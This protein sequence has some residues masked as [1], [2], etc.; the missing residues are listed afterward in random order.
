MNRRIKALETLRRLEERE[1]TALSRDLTA[2]QG[3]QAQAQAQVDALQKRAQTEAL[4]TA[5]EALPYIGRFLANLRRE[6]ARQTQIARNLDSTIETL[7]QEVLHHFAAEKTF[8]H[9][10]QAQKTEILTN[11]TRSAEA[12]LED[13][14]TSRFGRE[15][16]GR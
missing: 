2:A 15:T 16:S 4:T 6:Q 12:A 13:L 10:A 3:A 5:P 14:T 11:R 1:V 7:R 9:L 8:D